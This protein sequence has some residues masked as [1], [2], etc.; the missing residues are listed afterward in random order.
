VAELTKASYIRGTRLPTSVYRTSINGRFTAIR[1]QVTA[2][3]RTAD[4]PSDRAGSLET[5]AEKPIGAGTPVEV[6]T[7]HA[8]FD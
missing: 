3:F 5:L 2:I 7:L 4:Q 8:L 6:E 1:R